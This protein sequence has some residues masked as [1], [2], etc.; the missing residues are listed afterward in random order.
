[1]CQHKHF[2]IVISKLQI[3]ITTFCFV[4]KK[5]DTKSVDYSDEQRD[6]V[7]DRLKDFKESNNLP[8][9]AFPSNLTQQEVAC[10]RDVA[11]NLG[12]ETQIYEGTVGETFNFLTVRNS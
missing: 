1:M 9:M 2:S 5:P 10:V 4:D 3:F 8:E 11:K 7:L 12:L 6:V